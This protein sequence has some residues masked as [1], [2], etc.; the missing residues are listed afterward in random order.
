MSTTDH[1]DQQTSYLWQHENA[2]ELITGHGRIVAEY[3]DVGYTRRLPWSQRPKARDL[4]A[5]LADPERSFD[6][7][8]IGESERAFYGNQFFDLPPLFAEHGV[9]VW[10]PELC[11]PYDPGN[12]RT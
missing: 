12:P 10:L 9:Q 7:I 8:V 4:L 3:F 5:A 1:Q 11:G 6:A 2:S